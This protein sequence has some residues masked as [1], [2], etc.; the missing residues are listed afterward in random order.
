MK[1]VVVCDPIHEIGFKILSEAEDIEL[2]DA[3]KTPKDELLKIIEDA[4]GVITRSPTPVDDKFLNAVK[5]LKAVVRAGVGVDNV[6][7]DGASKKGIIVMNV[8]TANTIAAVEL[9]M[10]HLVSSMRAFPNAVNALKRDKEWNREKWL[11]NELYGKKLGVIG[12]GNIGSRVASRAKSF[13]MDIIAYD[14]YINPSKV[15]NIHCFLI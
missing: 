1:K 7:I 8:P 4:D 13:G 14:P 15:I 11:G 12:F 10:C 2:V 6:D 5:K 9:T 3:S